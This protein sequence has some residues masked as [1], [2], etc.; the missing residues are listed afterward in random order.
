VIHAVSA[1]D[2]APVARALRAR[3]GEVMAVHEGDL[4]VRLPLPAIRR[5]IR[6]HAVHSITLDA[7]MKAT[8]RLRQE[9]DR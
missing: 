7:P 6:L 8:R 3:W 9:P 1:P 5:L 2:V 4:Y